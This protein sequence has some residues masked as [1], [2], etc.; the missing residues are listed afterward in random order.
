[1]SVLAPGLLTYKLLY[2]STGLI[3]LNDDLQ[4]VTAAKYALTLG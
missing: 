4:Y 3:L 2:I 1:M